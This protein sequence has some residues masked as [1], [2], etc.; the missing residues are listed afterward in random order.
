MKYVVILLTIVSFTG[1]AQGRDVWSGIFDQQLAAAR[2]GDAD[3]QY[4]L[5]GMYKNG[6]GV[7]ADRDQAMAWYGK[8]AAQ[9][10]A[11]AKSALS[12]MQTVAK[13]VIARL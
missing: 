10:H 1:S 8:A 7:A 5:A 6:Q 13:G 3:A 9:K 4:S 2:R 11:R 12:L